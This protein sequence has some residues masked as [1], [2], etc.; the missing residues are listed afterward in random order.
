VKR[1]TVVFAP[2]AR[3][4]LFDLFD[5]IASA[6]GE[7]IARDYIA[8]LEAYCLSFDVA[9]E[10]GARHD[11]VRAGLRVVGFERR[12]SIAFTADKDRVTILRL[13]RAGRDWRRA[14]E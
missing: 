5:W 2:E 10:R 3:E 13:L 1:R 9:S 6:A 11:E 8:R 4:D 12:L 14:V 7:R